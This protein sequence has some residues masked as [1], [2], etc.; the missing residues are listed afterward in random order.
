MTWR[1]LQCRIFQCTGHNVASNGLRSCIVCIYILLEEWDYTFSH[2]EHG[3]IGSGQEVFPV[4]TRIAL[5][6]KDLSYCGGYAYMM[7]G[8]Q[9]WLMMNGSLLMNERTVEKYSDQ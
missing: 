1:C 6:R 4:W 9:N 5:T 3:T 8:V 2:D 7:I